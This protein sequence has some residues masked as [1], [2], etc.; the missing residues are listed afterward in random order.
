MNDRL[1]VY[2]TLLPGLAPAAVEDLV[3]RFRLVGTGSLPGRLYDL[4]PYPGAVFDASASTRVTGQVFEL[5]DDPTLL[6]RLDAYE[7]CVPG[8]PQNSQYLRV[9]L[10]ARLVEGCEVSCWAYAYNRPL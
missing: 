1:F 4:G 3:E 6:A 9:Q 8:D 10:L 2:G 5:P 7:G